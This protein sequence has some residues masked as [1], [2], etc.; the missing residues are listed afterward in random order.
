MK[1]PFPTPCSAAFCAGAA[2]SRR[3]ESI[4]E[5]PRGGESFIR[6]VSPPRR[7]AAQ[8]NQIAGANAGFRFRLWLI[9]GP[10]VAQLDR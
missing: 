4:S 8:F 2:L 7:V 9:R 10:G 5:V 1:W 3:G 6:A